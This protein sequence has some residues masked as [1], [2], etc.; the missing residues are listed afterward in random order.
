NRYGE[1]IK[2]FTGGTPG[3]PAHY[4]AGP[5]Y[6]ALAEIGIA[7]VRERSQSMTQPL[8]E[9]ALERGFTVRSPHDPA[10]RGGHVTIDPGDSQRVHDA[11]HE[12]GFVVDH[13]PGVGI[14]VSPHFY[15][16]LDEAMA[17]LDAMQIA[18]G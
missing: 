7:T 12:Q 2:R 6:D 15:N 11:L 16:S 13:R 5:A 10:K 14:R 8:L 17:C 9:S 4:A 18:Q 3:V 1:G